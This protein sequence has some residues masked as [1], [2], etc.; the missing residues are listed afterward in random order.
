MVELSAVVASAFI[1]AIATGLITLLL[2]ELR[3]ILKT[4]RRRERFRDA[5]LGEIDA[6]QRNAGS[7]EVVTKVG[8]G[9]MPT[10][11][12]DNNTRD[13]GLLTESEVKSI[14]EYY[15]SAEKLNSLSERVVSNP[16]EAIDTDSKRETHLASAYYS[17][18]DRVLEKG[19]QAISNL[20]E[21]KSDIGLQAYVSDF[22]SRRPS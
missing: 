11:V 20:Q 8:G 1:G 12:F 5:L 22:L 6:G 17:E 2:R 21:N 16:E 14:T 19:D 18:R 9:M 7:A 13:L 15:A 4:R 3:D 10:S